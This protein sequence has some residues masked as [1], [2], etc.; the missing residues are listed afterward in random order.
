MK[1]IVQAGG[2][3]T[4]LEWLTR[5]KPKCLVPVK[6]LPIIFHLF[7]KFPRDEF[8]VISDYKKEVLRG[9]LKAFATDVNYKIIEAQGTGTLSG[10]KEALS[11]IN[12]D[13]RF[14][15]SW[16]DLVLGSDFVIPSDNKNYVGISKSFECRW[17]YCN[18]K[19]IKKSSKE[20]GV[21]GVFI[22]SN[23]KILSDI[24]ESG[25]FVDYLERKK[26]VF[27]PIELTG[28]QEVGTIVSYNDI[29]SNEP[30]CRPFNEME[31]KSDIV[32]K[33]PADNFGKKIA[34]DEINWYKHV[35]SL[36]FQ[37][38]PQILSYEPLTMKRV[39]GKNIYEYD[40]LTKK[41]KICILEKIVEAINSLHHLEPE[42]PANLKDLEDNYVIKT[43]D[44]LSKVRDI[45]PF[46]NKEFIKINGQYYKNV[47]YYKDEFINA[48]RKFYPKSFTLIHG[49][50]TFSNIMFDSYNQKIIFIDPRG[51]FGTT[52]FYGDPDYDWAK[53]YYSLNGNYDQF[54]NKRFTLDIQS[55]SVEFVIK[56]NNWEDV[57]DELF[58]LTKDIKRRKIML[59][60]AVIWLSLTTYAWQ[61]YDS[62]CCAFYNGIVK[63]NEVI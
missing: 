34:F 29:V 51:Y 62:I 35:L 45:I 52:K 1:I 17:S 39:V 32:I 60:Q 41:Q 12:E 22:F 21:A 13:E 50:T 16:C 53:L 30:K 3:G 46:A 19:F 15:I 40:I 10:I 42:R 44:R 27:E 6:N 58:L 28:S 20:N 55:N 7:K 48:I 36:G 59:L 57:S 18:N 4:R 31:F 23:K 43:F 26:I 56:S 8:L 61:D 11:H 54:N 5:N 24:N 49:D 47:F 33:K 37:S 2:K 25:A 63:L 38:I 9:Y 14:M